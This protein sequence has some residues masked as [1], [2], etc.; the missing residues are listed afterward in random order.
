MEFDGIEMMRIIIKISKD[1]VHTFWSFEKNYLNV[2]K[3]FWYSSCWQRYKFAFKQ[4]PKFKKI[5]FGTI[6]F[7]SKDELAGKFLCFSSDVEV[8][9]Q[10][11]SLHCN[12][13]KKRLGLGVF[14]DA[15][16]VCRT[17]GT[18]SRQSE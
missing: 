2:L 3:S 11:L 8:E 18:I 9:M 12:A 6:R 5:E 17:N 14:I 16:R 13:K 4:W 15:E 1:Y 7:N 10:M